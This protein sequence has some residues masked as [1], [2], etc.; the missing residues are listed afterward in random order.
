MGIPTVRD[1]VVQ[2]AAKLVLEPIFEA[3]FLLSSYGF[4]PRRSAQ[5]ALERLRQLGNHGADHVL[6][7]DIETTWQ[8]RRQVAHF[9]GTTGRGPQGA[10]AGAVVVAGRRD[11]R[12]RGGHRR[13]ERRRVG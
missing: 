2:M 3:D 10:Q 9:G 12:R 5:M 4:R 6:D 11:G 13:R 8:H 7:A 1:R